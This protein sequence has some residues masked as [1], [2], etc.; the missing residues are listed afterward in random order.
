MDGMD[1]ADGRA[2]PAFAVDVVVG[3]AVTMA[4]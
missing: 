4:R 2:W 3:K 1:M